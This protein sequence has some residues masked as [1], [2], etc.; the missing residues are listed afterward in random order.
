MERKSS[1]E[2]GF[3]ISAFAPARELSPFHDDVSA[4]EANLKNASS[5]AAKF[6]TPYPSKPTSTTFTRAPSM[7]TR[8]ANK[9]ERRASWL[10]SALSSDNLPFAVVDIEKEERR[11]SL[12]SMLLSTSAA[13]FYS[14]CA[15]SMNF[16]NKAAL[17]AFP[18]ANTLLLL[19]M[20]AALAVVLPLRA[21]GLIYFPP[22]NATKARVLLPLTAL[23]AGNVSCALLGLRVLNV[24]MYSTLKRLTP[25]LVILAK[26][27]MT[28]TLPS[29]GICCS[30][31]I[32]VLGCFI[33]GSTDL[34][35]DLRGYTFAFA[36]CMLQ[37]AYL[38]LV[39]RTGTK[40][41]VSTSELLAYNAILSLPFILGAM[42]VSGEAF[43]VLPALHAAMAQHGTFRFIA[44]LVL[45]SLS[46]VA[47]NFSMFLCTLLNSAL[48]TTI[49]GTLK[50]VIVT[51]LGFFLLGGVPHHSA[52][53]ISGI[54]VNALG[55]TLYSIIKYRA[56]LS[57]S[58]ISTSATSTTSSKGNVS[59]TEFS[60]TPSSSTTLRSLIN[61][62]HSRREF[63]T[64]PMGTSVVRCP[65]TPIFARLD[66]SA[67]IKIRQ[68]KS[69]F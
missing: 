46:G 2:C 11:R 63:S 48:T 14:I 52:L 56:R 34:A 57:T 66:L 39:E 1:I 31:L 55:G 68:N 61:S 26:W 33:A 64:P 43:H 5:H 58:S 9:L 23:Y 6:T 32:V 37:A 20:L 4:A 65:P 7:L 30:V 19:Q 53:N 62:A 60:S 38:L 35:F 41:G 47:L 29:N 54:V 28:K 10:S 8:S 67:K 22:F 17:M 44:L 24:P 25:L 13:V 36:S 69:L 12:R 15:I 21:L 49:V 40:T 42:V 18:F 3:S 50:G 51:V 45:C 27:R 59:P 16:T